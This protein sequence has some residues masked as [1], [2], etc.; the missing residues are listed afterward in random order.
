MNETQNSTLLFCR[1]VKKRQEKTET[2]YSIEFRN[3]MYFKLVVNLTETNC[4][5]N[6]STRHFV[7]YS[8]KALDKRHVGNFLLLQNTQGAILLEAFLS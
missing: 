7:C 5:A 1:A 2:K 6:Y 3:V 8:R 4:F